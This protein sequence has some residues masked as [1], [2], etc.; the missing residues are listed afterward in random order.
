MLKNESKLEINE[1]DIKFLHS[2]FE[3]KMSE[4][5]RAYEK[6]FRGKLRKFIT[7]SFVKISMM[8]DVSK[9]YPKLKDAPPASK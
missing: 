4:S 2:I 7:R 1:N 3:M 9:T 5:Q 6:T 8:F